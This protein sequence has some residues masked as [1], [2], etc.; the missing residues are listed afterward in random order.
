MI[1]TSAH[2]QYVVMRVTLLLSGMPILDW[3]RQAA[4]IVRRILG[5]PDYERYVAHVQMAHPGQAPMSE[6][7]FFRERLE[8]RAKP[9]SRCC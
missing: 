4:A 3:L 9:G 8:G 7:E 2:R 5:V 6:E 1:G